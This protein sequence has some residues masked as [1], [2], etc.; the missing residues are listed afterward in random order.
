MSWTEHEIRTGSIVDRFEEVVSL[1][2]DWP[3]TRSN[4]T[5]FTYKELNRR[6]NC[7]ARAIFDSGGS[8][9]VPVAL[10]FRSPI[11]LCAPML[12]SLKAG[13]FFTP[14]DPSYPREQLDYIIA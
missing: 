8:T 3:A 2:P 1:F 6:S 5:E 14:L 13:R 11:G 12:G 10:L 4:E 9:E 7:A